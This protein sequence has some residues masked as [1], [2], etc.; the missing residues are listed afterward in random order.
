E[1]IFPNRKNH[2][3]PYEVGIQLGLRIYFKY[4]AGWVS[5]RRHAAALVWE[6]RHG[7]SRGIAVA[8]VLLWTSFDSCTLTQETLTSDNGRYVTHGVG[9]GALEGRDA[10]RRCPPAPGVRCASVVGGRE[11]VGT[12]QALAAERVCGAG[13]R[14]CHM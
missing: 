4:R 5:G 8:S 2:L 1:H 10:R 3:E 11:G 13:P 6:Q 9:A 14:S 12:R 7:W